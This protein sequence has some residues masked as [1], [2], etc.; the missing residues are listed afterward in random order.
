MMNAKFEFGT[1]KYLPIMY[2]VLFTDVAH[3]WHNK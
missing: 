1:L 2:T 3:C